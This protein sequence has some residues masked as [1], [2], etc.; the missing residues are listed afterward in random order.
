[1]ESKFDFS[2]FLGA[3]GF[4]SALD[5]FIKDVEIERGDIGE[6][7]GAQSGYMLPRLL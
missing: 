6:E 7:L 1:M 3:Y 2:T 5:R 4:W